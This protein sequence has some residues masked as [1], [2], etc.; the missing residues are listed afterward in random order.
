MNIQF[1]AIK[2][3][4]PDESAA[5]AAGL[6]MLESKSPPAFAIGV[7]TALAAVGGKELPAKIWVRYC[8][9]HA[10]EAKKNRI[11]FACLITM[12]TR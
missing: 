3:E 7:P 1:S 6:I 2:K 4:L 10:V 8:W 12:G 9:A 5:T 11:R